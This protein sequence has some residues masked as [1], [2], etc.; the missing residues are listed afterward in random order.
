MVYRTGIQV[1]R[2]GAGGVVMLM[3][4]KDTRDDD[5]GACKPASG[6]LS[7]PLEGVSTAWRCASIADAALPTQRSGK[8]IL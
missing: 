2:L 3:H 4:H 7:G 8:A 6:R 1:P 5:R